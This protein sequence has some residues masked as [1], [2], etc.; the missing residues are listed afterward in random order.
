LLAE[1]SGCPVLAD[2]L[3]DARHRAHSNT[4]AS[5]SA[6]IVSAYDAILR[7]ESM[8]AALAPEL[9]FCVGGWPTSK[10]LR[11]WLDKTQPEILMLAPTS[12][13]RDALHGRTRF[14]P[15][16][17][18]D[19]EA[20]F[21]SAV[22][23]RSG[24]TALLDASMPMPIVVNRPKRCRRSLAL[25][26]PP[27][28]KKA[29][30]A[31]QAAWR[32]AET[33]ARAALDGALAGIADTD[34]FEPRAAWLLAQHL[35]ERT[36]IFVASSM[37]VRD[38]EYFWPVT[39]RGH[40]FHFNRGANG[41]DGTLSTA[42]G[43]AHDNDQPA[44]LLTGDLALLHDTNGFLIAMQ[45]AV[46]A[47]AASPCPKN[48]GRLPMPPEGRGL[49]AR[50]ASKPASEPTG[51]QP[52]PRRFRGSLTIVLINNNGGGIFESL[53]AAKFDPP[54]EEYFATPQNIDFAKLCATYGVG[55]TLIESWSQ[56][57][58][59]ITALPARG[60]RVL[61]IR[62]DRKRDTARRKALLAQACA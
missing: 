30:L 22:A 8:A 44:V 60:V 49:A 18:P 56:F 34:L 12:R 58:R 29:S 14:L 52:V 39:T 20:L 54:F 10:V 50:A 3:S 48:M 61:E 46:V 28:S 47:R 57:T 32:R 13:N 17:S 2:V 15:E 16:H 6:T 59:L 7:N 23:E 9:V 41:I 55:H 5:T 11:A 33:S 45:N 31:Y 26:L 62:A 42:L 25:P 4:N 35:P 37:P 53:P 40:R 19:D 1:Q 24:D 43:V 38:A 36:P 51:W 21:W 27:H